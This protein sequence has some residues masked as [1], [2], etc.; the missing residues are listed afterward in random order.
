MKNLGKSGEAAHY[1]GLQK[2]A[3]ITLYDDIPLYDFSNIAH[4][5]S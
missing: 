4:I 1:S 2:P 5:F 3:L